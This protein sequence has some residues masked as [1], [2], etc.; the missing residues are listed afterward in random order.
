MAAV[1]DTWTTLPE[2]SDRLGVDLPG[3]VRAL[4]AVGL[5][6]ASATPSAASKKDE[7]ARWMARRGTPTQFLWHEGRVRAALEA[8]GVA[9]EGVGAPMQAPGADRAVWGS[10]TRLGH[11]LGTTA[12]AA[13][14]QLR[15]DG[16]RD[17][18][19][20]PTATAIDAALVRSW[21]LPNGRLSY[22]WHLARTTAVLGARHLAL[23]SYLSLAFRLAHDLRRLVSVHR[24]LTSP[25]ALAHAV[26]GT[27]PARHA[28]ALEEQ[29]LGARTATL[30]AVDALLQSPADAIARRVLA[31]LLDLPGGL[32]DV[33]PDLLDAVRA[34]PPLLATA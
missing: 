17:A 27:Y 21:V 15:A 12:R 33:T 10:L 2:L 20:H 6:S 5:A 30:L 1:A 8:R 22:A 4:Q 29:S 24:Q 28:G 34:A 3:T 11:G 31:A 25:T 23:D 13:G 7:I 26:A 19:G 16:L 32:W 9:A 14:E 18:W